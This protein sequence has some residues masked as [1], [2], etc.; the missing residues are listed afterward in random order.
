M[1]ETIKDFVFKGKIT[2]G[3]NK[4]K[5]LIVLTT[6]LEA[7]NDKAPTVSKLV[8]KCKERGL[9]CIVIDT[10][11]GEIEKT[12]SGLYIIGDKNGK[13]SEVDINN[14]VV[15]ARR[16]AIESTGAIKF[17]QKLESI[18]FISI[19]SLKSVM[20]CEDKL[21]TVE[22]LKEKG[23]SVPKTALV[24]SE[25]DI[26]SSLE[27]IGGVFPIVVKLLSGTKGIGVFQI[28]SHPSLIST[29]QAIW[30]LSQDTEL[31]L[32]EKIAAE[33]DLRIHVLGSKAGTDEG[34]NYKVIGAMRRNKI[35]GDFR[36]N[37][38]LGGETEKV[39]LTPEIEKMA[40]ESA[41]C[42][43]CSWCGVDVIVSEEDERPYVLEVNASPG[44]SGIEKTTELPITDMVL[45]FIM[46][47]KNW[48]Y[49]IKMIGFREVFTIKGVGDFVGKS[50]TGNGAI[51][52][53]VHADYFEEEEGFMS[54]TIG[55]KSFRHRVVEY[56]KAEIGEKI[57]KRPVILLDIEFD[58]TVYRDV[59]FSLVDRTAKSTPLL[60]NRT[61][62][63]LA[64]IV[65]D[66][67]RTFLVSS[68]P[69]DYSPGKAKG[70]AI[71][72]IDVI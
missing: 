3:D 11:S 21:D 6:K 2:S 32:Q 68:V 61:F 4:A 62:M 14:S 42:T 24:S 36:T 49:P 54:W 44:T 8:E 37:F 65:V 57:E 71:A 1:A 72:G 63:E 64:G 31:I 41:K 52:C 29:L 53:S 34:F 9:K 22:L 33:Y 58:G 18:G 50:D 38:S 19:N 20:L 7:K 25:N 39:E 26:E 46:E 10:T 56:S 59:K 45:D 66:P 48:N 47:K 69:G 43:G 16:S 35:T 13:K 17:F 12:S 55:G 15:L 40:I 51:S 23:I 70:V 28:D 30:K 67:S 60:L 27:K 5:A